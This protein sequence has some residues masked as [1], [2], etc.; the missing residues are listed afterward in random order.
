MNN[1]KL[2]IKHSKLISWFAVSKMDE[3]VLN[4]M[5]KLQNRETK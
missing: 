5:E 2:K 3:G 1:L 4:I